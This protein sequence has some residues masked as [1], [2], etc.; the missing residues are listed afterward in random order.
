M[1]EEMQ[2]FLKDVDEFEKSAK[3]TVERHEELIRTLGEKM[4]TKE[5]LDRLAEQAGTKER[6]LSRSQCPAAPHDVRSSGR[7]GGHQP[8]RAAA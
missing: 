5:Q 3:E 4:R 8:G 2:D 6:T 7:A 1:A